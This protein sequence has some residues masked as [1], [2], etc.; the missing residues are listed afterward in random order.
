VG[1]QAGTVTL[2][3]NLAVPQKLEIVLPED[4]TTR[5][6]NVLTLSVRHKHLRLI[7]FVNV[8]KFFF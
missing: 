3:I 5:S 7:L 4:H 8:S 6:E 1:L 2:E